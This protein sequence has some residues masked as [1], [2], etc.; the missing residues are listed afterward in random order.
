MSP[1]ASLLCLN[2]FGQ[3]V[4]SSYLAAS[5]LLEL[6]LARR[7]L[8][9][10]HSACLMNERPQESFKKI[11]TTTCSP[12]SKW[13]FWLPVARWSR[14]IVT[15]VQLKLSLWFKVRSSSVASFG[16][17]YFSGVWWRRRTKLLV[18]VAQITQQIENI[19]KLSLET[20]IRTGNS[21][22]SEW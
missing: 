16:A 4:I 21:S 3:L 6:S 14:P 1:A 12:G 11:P 10:G 20:E 18:V 7:Q 2:R 22:T 13:L 8:S 17:P 19:Y 15:L 5:R 9:D